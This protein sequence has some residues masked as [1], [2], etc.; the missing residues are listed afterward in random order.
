MKLHFVLLQS[1]ISGSLFGQ[2]AIKLLA[3]PHH[4]CGSFPLPTQIAVRLARRSAVG[5]PDHYLTTGVFHSLSFQ[6]IS[7]AQA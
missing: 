5:L 3:R 6:I 2:P 1:V 4:F 7:A